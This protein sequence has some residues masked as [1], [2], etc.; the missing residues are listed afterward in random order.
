M[1]LPSAEKN[2]GTWPLMRPILT[3]PLI[4]PGMS[5]ILSSRNNFLDLLAIRK[6]STLLRLRTAQ[7]VID[8][9]QFYNVGPSQ[10]PGMIVMRI[11]GQSPSAYAGANYKSV[12]VVF[13]VDKLAKNV[14]VASL[15]GKTLV[16]H[17]TQLASSADT[18][19]KS[20]SFNK[21]SGTF[22]IPA[23]TVAV[24]VE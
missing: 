12:V 1:G 18:V 6:S 5:E 15:S 20:A 14:T 17:P 16:L 11:D 10:V 2:Q 19:V 21:A 9:L 4:K 24:F 23:R 7:D 8:R 3:N 13:N 22:S